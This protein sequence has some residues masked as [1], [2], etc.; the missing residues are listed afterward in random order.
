M[1][2]EAL[3]QGDF[4]KWVFH[5]V[6]SKLDKAIYIFFIFLVGVICGYVWCF[7]ALTP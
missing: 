7:M 2:K 3:L 5:S 6:S 4:W 1:S